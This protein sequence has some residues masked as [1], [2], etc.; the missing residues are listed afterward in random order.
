MV[1]K[2]AEDTTG[3]AG[4][5]G[6]PGPRGRTGP[7]APAGD[8]HRL[9]A[10]PHPGVDRITFTGESGTGKTIAG[11]AAANLVPVSLELG[12]KGANI[13]FDDADLD[14]AVAWSIRAIFSN[15]ATVCLAGSRLYVQRGIYAEFTDASWPP[16][17]PWRL[18]D[19]KDEA[20]EARPAGVRAAL[21]RRSAAYL[22]GRRG[23]RRQDQHRRPAG[24]GWVV[25]PTVIEH[26]PLAAR[27]C[28]EEIFGPVVTSHPSTIDED[29]IR[30]PTTPATA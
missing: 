23:R 22:D 18:G 13:V 17:R 14:N 30:W 24:D 21:P 26:A 16:P 12:G 9:G 3:A 20:T 5:D 15:A 6:Q 11:A 19:P 2:P 28:R 25:L 1:L 7:R 4:A 29:A 27:S 8:C 10:D